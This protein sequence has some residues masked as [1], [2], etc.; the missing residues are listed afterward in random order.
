M[1]QLEALLASVVG[2]AEAFGRQLT[3]PGQKLYLRALHDVPDEALAAGVEA[4]LKSNREF[5]PTPGQLRTICL[6]NGQTPE[7][8]ALAAWGVVAEATRYGGR[9]SVQFAD[10]AITRTIRLLGKW[11]EFN[12]RFRSDDLHWLR[13]EFL[14]T[15]QHTLQHAD[16][17]PD[18]TLKGTD[19]LEQ[20][21][22]SRD[23]YGVPPVLLIS[24]PYQPLG[25]AALPAAEAP[26]IQFKKP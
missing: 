6:L 8:R 15:Y 7:S 26:K 23:R 4:V 14:E 10:R 22:W 19:A 17:L 21:E 2:L 13:K 9:Q 11:P 1:A 3:E 12:R 24:S 5:M 25:Q 16:E 18:E 20:T